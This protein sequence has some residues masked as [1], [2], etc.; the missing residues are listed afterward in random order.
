MLGVASNQ[1]KKCAQA[2]LGVT[3]HP[4]TIRKTRNHELILP[5][6]QKKWQARTDLA[7]ANPRKE[8]K[9]KFTLVNPNSTIRRRREPQN[10]WK[11]L[12]VGASRNTTRDET[13]TTQY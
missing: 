6:R 13:T 7:T 8:N 10:C 1:L 11:M 2:S 12:G 4:L 3:A 9:Q 5:H